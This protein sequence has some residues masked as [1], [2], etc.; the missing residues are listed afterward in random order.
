VRGEGARL[1][2]DSTLYADR[3]ALITFGEYSETIS[4]SRRPGIAGR[5]ADMNDAAAAADAYACS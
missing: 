4:A 2:A 1:S 3:C 5:Y